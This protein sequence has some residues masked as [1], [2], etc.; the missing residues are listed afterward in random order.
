[1]DQVYL[2]QEFIQVEVEDQ[3]QLQ[4]VTGGTG[5]GGSGAGGTSPG[6]KVQQEQL[7]QVEEVVVVEKMWYSSSTGGAGGSGIVIVK[8]L[9]KATGVWS[10]KS[11]FSA[12]K[13]GTWV[14]AQC[15]VSLDYL[16]VAGGG[17]TRW[18]TW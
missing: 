17:G 18:S 3:V 4:M 7:I 10:L 11:Q 14:Q 13:S 9:N 5:G 16:V 6:N 12:V 15:S 8:E 2:I 1:L